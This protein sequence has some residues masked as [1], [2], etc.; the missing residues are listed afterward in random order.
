MRAQ[1]SRILSSDA[2]ARSDRM[3]RFL[4]YVVEQWMKHSDS[5]LK[6]YTIALAVYDKPASFDSRLD[7][8]IRVEASRLRAKLREYYEDEGS[9]D[10]IAISLRKRGY[11]AVIKQRNSRAFQDFSVKIPSDLLGTIPLGTKSEEAHHFFLK[12]RYYW[13]KR[14]QESMSEAVS[15][16]NRAIELDS[17]YALAYA[18]LGDCYASQAWLDMQAPGTLW[19]LAE[20]ASRRAMEIDESLTQATTTLACKQALFEWDWKKAEASFR[21]AIEQRAQIPDRAS[22]VC[23]LLPGASAPAD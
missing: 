5:G 6:E 19:P 7:P 14:T 2:F 3:K 15:F 4:S 22:L 18:G 12:G 21:R 8:I 11:S 17:H 1:L 23:D 20:K 9:N 16:F 13:N 10:G